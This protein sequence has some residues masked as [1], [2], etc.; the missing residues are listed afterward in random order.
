MRAP[1]APA[2]PPAVTPPSG[3]DTSDAPGESAAVRHRNPNHSTYAWTNVPAYNADPGEN[4]Y[5]YLLRQVREFN[6]G[7]THAADFVRSGI[8]QY[9]RPEQQALCWTSIQTDLARMFDY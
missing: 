3:P 7:K 4:P 6:M 8:R 2:M 1:S 5:D 9:V